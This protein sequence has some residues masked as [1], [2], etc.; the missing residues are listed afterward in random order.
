MMTTESYEYYSAQV[1]GATDSELAEARDRSPLYDAMCEASE[2]LADLDRANYEADMAALDREE[3]TPEEVED[4]HARERDEISELRGTYSDMH[5]EWCGCRSYLPA[6][7][8]LVDARE[9][10][11]DLQKLLEGQFERERNEEREHAWAYE[12]ATNTLIGDRFISVH[13]EFTRV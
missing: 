12:R 10:V 11:A 9:A 7:I 5:K 1:A 8:S 6:D 13:L 2:A 3:L 4:L